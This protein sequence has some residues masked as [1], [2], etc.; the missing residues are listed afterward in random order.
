MSLTNHPCSRCGDSI[1]ADDEHSCV[2]DGKRITKHGHLPSDSYWAILVFH[3]NMATY[4]AY[5][6]SKPWHDEITALSKRD[7]KFAAFKASA[8]AKITPAYS[9]DIAL[10]S[11]WPE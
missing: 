7:A 1:F 8:P 3:T 5:Q 9:V 10:D 2:E 6:S 4:H 11:S